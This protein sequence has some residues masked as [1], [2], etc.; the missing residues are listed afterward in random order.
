LALLAA[1]IE[2]AEPA[3]GVDLEAAAAAAVAADA[4]AAAAVPP[5][6]GDALLPAAT[7][8]PDLTGVP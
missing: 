3:G 8:A 7:A 1:S 2:A 5:D 6:F 4:A